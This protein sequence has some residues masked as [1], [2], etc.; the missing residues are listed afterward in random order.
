MLQD[1]HS[2]T[3]HPLY[4]QHPTQ[5]KPAVIYKELLISTDIM[6][7]VF[8]MAPLRKNRKSTETKV[9]KI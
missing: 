3:K 1:I 2:Y 4:L 9:T 7:S 5:H 8:S 6:W